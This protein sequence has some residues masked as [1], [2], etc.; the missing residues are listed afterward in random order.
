MPFV[1]N[2]LNNRIDELV[3]ANQKEGDQLRTQL[4]NSVQRLDQSSRFA[5][6]EQVRQNIINSRTEAVKRLSDRAER[7]GLNDIDQLGT[8]EDWLA[9][10]QE[11]EDTFLPAM[12]ENSLT[13]LGLPEQ[14]RR[15]IGKKGDDFALSF[16]DWKQVRQDLT[17][18]IQQLYQAG[19]NADASRIG[20]FADMWDD[21][22][23]KS[24]EDRL[25]T[26]QSGSPNLQ[27]SGEK[28]LSYLKDYKNEVSGP[29]EN[30]FF[31]PIRQRAGG[32]DDFPLYQTNAENVADTFLNSVE[33]VRSY[34]QLYGPDG[35]VKDLDVRTQQMDALNAAL[36]DRAYREAFKKNGE[37]DTDKFDAF[38]NKYSEVIDELRMRA[39]FD[40]IRN[41]EN[42]G[43]CQTSPFNRAWRG[44]KT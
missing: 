22:A 4:G 13:F 19:N 16:Q 44:Y 39:E 1:L 6:G 29:F 14:L 9:F 37:I 34:K 43:L 42:E 23:R 21:F 25:T 18:S 30:R 10:R 31:V 27:R 32:T 26:L 15:V 17:N 33:G 12:G 8:N 24:A 38:L 40:D 5:Q 36:R 11:V 3:A 35:L 41:I 7:E 28:L 2:K 20:L